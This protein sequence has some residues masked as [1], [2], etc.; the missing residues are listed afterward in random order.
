MTTNS[1][2]A[3]ILVLYCSTIACYLKWFEVSACKVLVHLSSPDLVF[4]HMFIV[5]T[6]FLFSHSM[7]CPQVIQKDLEDCKAHITALETLVSSSQGNRVQFERLCAD[8]KHLHKTVMV[9]W[10]TKTVCSFVAACWFVEVRFLFCLQTKVHESEDNIAEH[11]NFHDSLLNIEKWLMIMKQKL[12][13]FHT[14]SGK[15]SIEGRQ[16]EAEVCLCFV[17]F[18]F[19]V[20]FPL[21]CS[22]H[23]LWAPW[24]YSIWRNWNKS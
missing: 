2:V 3:S 5:V 24:R 4:E 19:C 15:W 10:E 7:L 9:K 13:S 16:H 8:W 22:W 20:F 11:E 6:F 1:S 21:L 18:F 12:E 14:P 17:L 23:F